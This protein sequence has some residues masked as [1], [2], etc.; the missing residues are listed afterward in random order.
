MIGTVGFRKL[1][2]AG[3]KVGILAIPTLF[4]T[5]LD[6][7]G[8]LEF[9][10]NWSEFWSKAMLV[11]I[12]LRL[13][14]SKLL[15]EEKVNLSVIRY[16]D[17]LSNSVSMVLAAAVLVISV[18]VFFVSIKLLIL[19]T[20]LAISSLIVQYFRFENRLF[21]SLYSDKQIIVFIVLMGVIFRLSTVSMLL[22]I[23]HMSLLLVYFF[24]VAKIRL[25][26]PKIGVSNFKYAILE[27]FT[28]GYKYIPVII[29]SL[30][31]EDVVIGKFT[32][33]S[34][35]SLIIQLPLVLLSF[36]NSDVIVDKLKNNLT[37]NL[38]NSIG[39]ISFYLGLLISLGILGYF[40]FTGSGIGVML[41]LASAM[42]VSNIVGPV[43]TVLVGL[44]KLDIMIFAVLVTHLIVWLFYYLHLSGFGLFGLILSFSIQV[45]VE[46]VVLRLYL[47]RMA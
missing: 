2:T 35:L 19:A 31:L 44:G 40:Y 43:H 30:Y 36:V 26:V 4:A 14:T 45:A 23:V 29:G 39:L 25:I 9:L 15:L 18:L 3:L 5:T 27:F 12:F 11:S 38:L 46:N 16:R 10:G 21:L 1:L 7:L 41:V 33:L 17:G 47:I 6:Y 32:Y 24:R 20:Y 22:I 42:S 8:E 34:S 13:G 37:S 28:L